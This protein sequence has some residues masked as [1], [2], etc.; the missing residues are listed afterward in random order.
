MVIAFSKS[1]FLEPSHYVAHYGKSFFYVLITDMKA[2]DYQVKHKPSSGDL[3]HKVVTMFENPDFMSLLS[4]KALDEIIE[5]GNSGHEE[6]KKLT[7]SNCCDFGLFYMEL[8]SAFV[9]GLW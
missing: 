9:I 2:E 3:K 6:R 5:I 8:E 7:H 4:N 1:S